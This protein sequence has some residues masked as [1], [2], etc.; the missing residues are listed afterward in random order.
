M[1]AAESSQTLAFRFNSAS[2]GAAFNFTPFDP[3]AG[4]LESME[5]TF[6]AT[7]RHDW[8]VWNADAIPQAVGFTAELTGTSVSFDGSTFAFAELDYGPAV[9]PILAFT[10][11]VGFATEFLAGRTQFL[12]GASPSFPSAFHSSASSI[13][14]G[15]FSV[16]VSFSGNL[17][18]SFDPGFWT[19][20]APNSF[21]GSL[22]DVS[23]A[24]T[25]T[26]TYH[27]VTDPVPIPAVPEPA[28][29]AAAIATL[30]GVIAAA[31]LSWRKIGVGS[32]G[33]APLKVEG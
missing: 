33:S 17:L 31:R 4:I 1:K 15:G 8:A 18:G 6:T 2:P 12:S 28:T 11:A 24:I 30:I 21:A 20:T 3:T 26:Y 22:V 32:G 9:T 10:P 14:T 19:I 16:P 13:V 25:A 5:I 27:A 7:R 23:G 29:G